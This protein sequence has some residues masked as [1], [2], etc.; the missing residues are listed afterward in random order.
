MQIIH[1][2]TL[3]DAGN[4]SNLNEWQEIRKQIKD[5]IAAV[6][7]P[8]NSGRFTIYPES[9]KERGKGNGVKPIKEAMMLHLQSSGWELE[10]QMDIATVSRPGNLDAV[11]STSYGPVAAEWETGNISSSHRAL[12]KM[13]L[14]LLKRKLVGGILIVPSRNL[15]QYLTDRVGNWAELE[16]YLDLWK[17]ISCN[18]GILQV[19]IVEHDATST[20]VD[21]ITKGTDGRALA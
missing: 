7:W 14:G 5:G 19:V 2:E 13:A 4:F 8:P 20:S 10:K 21:R 15:Y 17:S 6:Q 1:V 16:P 3:I 9:G 11:K 18:N 12:N